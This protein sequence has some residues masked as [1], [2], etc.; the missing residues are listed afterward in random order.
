MTVAEVCG[1]S[2]RRIVAQA[3]AV[4]SY[5]GVTQCGLPMAQVARTLGVTSIVV[6][7]GLTRAPALLRTRHLT[8]AAL[9]VPEKRKAP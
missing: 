5:V 1:G 9:V 2:R 4:V 6:R 3:R 7:T 8:A